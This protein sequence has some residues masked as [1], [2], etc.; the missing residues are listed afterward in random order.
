MVDNDY[1]LDVRKILTEGFH[2]TKESS[3]FLDFMGPEKT[4]N[5]IK[6][7]LIALRCNDDKTFDVISTD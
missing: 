1:L 3:K 6:N 4:V 2:P 7:R 5:G